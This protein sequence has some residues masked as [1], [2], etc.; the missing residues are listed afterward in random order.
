MPW[1]IAPKSAG[2]GV[3]VERAIICAPGK[4]LAQC[5]RG[6]RVVQL[7]RRTGGWRQDVETVRPNSGREPLKRRGV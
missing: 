1:I 2:L 3:R 5:V 7:N 4:D 6:T